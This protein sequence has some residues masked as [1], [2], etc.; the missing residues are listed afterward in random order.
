MRLEKFLADETLEMANEDETKQNISKC[1]ELSDYQKLLELYIA[2]E[3]ILTDSQKFDFLD[4][5]FNCLS[6][7]NTEVFDINVMKQ[8]AVDIGDPDYCGHPVSQQL[9]MVV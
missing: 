7:M 8:F 4:V 2:G 9:A 1:M 5:F 6:D 3:A